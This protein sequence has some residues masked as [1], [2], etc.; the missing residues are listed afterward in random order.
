MGDLYLKVNESGLTK[1][2][3]VRV[4][5]GDFATAMSKKKS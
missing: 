1:N 4:F 5:F 2:A 3:A